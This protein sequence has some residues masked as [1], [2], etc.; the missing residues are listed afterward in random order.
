MQ[1]PEHVNHDIPGIGIVRAREG[2]STAELAGAVKFWHDKCMSAR[3]DGFIG[4]TVFT[5]LFT[6]CSFG[7]VHLLR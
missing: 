4:G 2:T 6:L 1:S 3:R 5:L 7:V